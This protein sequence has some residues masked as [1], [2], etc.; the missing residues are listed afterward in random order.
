MCR[1]SGKGRRGEGLRGEGCSTV[2]VLGVEVVSNG[3][4]DRH[5]AVVWTAQR[6]VI[7]P[8]TLQKPPSKSDG[9][10]ARHGAMSSISP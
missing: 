7:S 1:S 9:G 8:I 2:A 10:S 3:G 6:L 5:C 4:F